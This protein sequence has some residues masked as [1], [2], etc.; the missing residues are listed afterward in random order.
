MHSIQ[1][2][3]ENVPAENTL[4]HHLNKLDIE[5]LELV[6]P[7]LLTTPVGDILDAD[8]SYLFAV[9]LTDDPYYGRVTD[10]NKEYVVGGKCKKSTTSFY[11]YATLYLIHNDIRV[12]I[13]A[14]PIRKKERKHEYLAR[15]LSVVDQLGL[16]IEVLLMDR[17]FYSS[18]VFTYLQANEIAHISP[19]KKHGEELKGLLEGRRS[20]T[21][22]YM[23]GGEQPVNLTIAVKVKYLMG[24]KNKK[25]EPQHGTENLGY[26]VYGVPLKPAKIHHLYKKRF[27]IEASYRMRNIVRP[28]T[29]TQNPMIRYLYTLISLLLKN[30]WVALCW[31]FF[32]PVRRGPR[33]IM[34]DAFR[35]AQFLH[36][37]WIDAGRRFGFRQIIA[38]LRPHG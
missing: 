7:Q 34:K 18:C 35:F 9:D 29:S 6:N 27:G 23:M 28:R 21:F 13:A 24:R 3:V 8:R 32:C 4:R 36:M 1:G 38:T 15:L 26:V 16:K 33:R 5:A 17:G 37:L 11:R 2:M 30:I 31:R 10:R 12:T 25:G 14:I 22:E 20:R 19:V